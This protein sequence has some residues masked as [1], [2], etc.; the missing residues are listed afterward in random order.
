MESDLKWDL[1][2]SN[3]SIRNKDINYK[4]LIVCKIRKYHNLSSVQKEQDLV[5]M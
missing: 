5:V 1:L 4:F 3:T 2:I